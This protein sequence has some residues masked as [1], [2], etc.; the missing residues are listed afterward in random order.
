MCTSV[1]FNNGSFYF[2]RNMDLE[3]SFGE[4]VVI[5]P[6]NFTFEYRKEA[7][8]T[9]HYAM[10]GMA[11]VVSGYPLFADAMNEKG[12]C[13]AGLNFPGNAVYAKEPSKDKANVTPFELIPWILGKCANVDEVERLLRETELVA[14]P[15]SENYPLTP[16]HWHIADK[17]RSLAVEPTSEGLKIYPNPVGVLTNNPPFPYHTANLVRY[18][19]LG[20]GTPE[21][22]W[23]SEAGAVS[24]GLC[25]T[26]LPGDYSS[27][28]R[29]VRAAFLKKHL[30]V[31]ETMD[32]AVASVFQLLGAVAPT[33]GSVFTPEG[34]PHYTT[35]TCCMDAEQGTYY[36]KRH[37]DLC[38]QKV[39]PRCNS[40]DG[41]A[42]LI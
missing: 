24:F 26:G 33:K 16:L 30:L 5:A 14:I 8:V 32:E 38:L 27:V 42:L 11:A 6:R 3:G 21:D 10:L 31:G 23:T 25:G 36:Y 39:H 41:D 9:R 37:E 40:L 17:Q 22:D 12:L 28:S 20:T 19:N 35:Y 1:A 7:A 4:R 18:A 34:K 13:M 15:F 29:F 2:G